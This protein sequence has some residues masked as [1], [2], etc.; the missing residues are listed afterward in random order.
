MLIPY[1]EAQIKIKYIQEWDLDQL[2]YLV[3]KV[4]SDS[5]SFADAT[6]DPEELLFI[7]VGIE[8]T[9]TAE[10]YPQLTRVLKLGIK[11]KNNGKGGWL[12]LYIPDQDTWATTDPPLFKSGLF[13]QDLF[14]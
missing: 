5:V 7:G 1:A 9:L 11:Q 6:F 13:S 12:Q 3:G 14:S 4:N 10:G 8:Q 2:S